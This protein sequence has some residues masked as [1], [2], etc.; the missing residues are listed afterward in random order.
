MLI[1]FFVNAAGRPVT[2]FIESI[3]NFRA[4][5]D[6]L[7]KTSHTKGIG[8]FARGQAGGMTKGPAEFC[9]G[10][11]H[12]A[13]NDFPA[14]RVRGVSEEFGGLADEGDGLIAILGAATAA[15]A[16]AVLFGVGRSLEKERV[17]TERAA[18]RAGRTAINMRG[19]NCEEE[20]AVSAAITGQSGLP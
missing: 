18:S 15:G 17:A 3:G 14:K 2:A 16:E 9:R 10:D 13:G 4:F 6:Q 19:A 1:R 7:A 11:F 20:S 5:A 8:K 12:F